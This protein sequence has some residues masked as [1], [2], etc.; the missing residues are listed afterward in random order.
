MVHTLRGGQ[1]YSQYLGHI[2]RPCDTLACGEQP[3]RSL[4]RSIESKIRSG[5]PPHTS[6]P[7]ISV[8]PRCSLTRHCHKRDTRSR[9]DMRLCVLSHPVLGSQLASS[10]RYLGSTSRLRR[11]CVTKD[12]KPQPHSTRGGK[13]PS[14]ILV[15]PLMNLKMPVS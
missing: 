2:R 6:N 13:Q 8:A 15:P 9:W 7:P 10:G 3:S 5:W 1:Q 4:Y 12:D 14:S 11:Y